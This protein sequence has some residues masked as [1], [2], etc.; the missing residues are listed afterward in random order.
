MNVAFLSFIG[1][2]SSAWHDVVDR[3][4]PAFDPQRSVLVGDHNRKNAV[5]SL[6][7]ISAADLDKKY[8]DADQEKFIRSLFYQGGTRK[9]PIY[10][11]KNPTTGLYFQAGYFE[12]VPLAEL[13]PQ[14]STSGKA[15]VVTKL[16]FHL[17]ANNYDIGLLQANPFFNGAVFQVASNFSTLEPSDKNAGPED[18]TLDDY[19]NDKTQGP[20]ASLS[21]LPGLFLRMYGVFRQQ[22]PPYSN[23]VKSFYGAK[24][25]LDW[26]QANDRQVEL[27]S[28]TGIPVQNGYIALYGVDSTGNWE[29]CCSA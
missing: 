3:V 1:L 2:F 7:G 23:P 16:R 22:G 4:R 11:I 9:R 5:A 21:A 29:A 18:C 13:V 28:E 8:R 10:F 17:L 24:S 6:I 26:R 27:L 14:A 25:P 12:E 20:K 19:E 15:E